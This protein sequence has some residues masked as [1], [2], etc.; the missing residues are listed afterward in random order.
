[1]ID[2]EA[3]VQFCEEYLAKHAYFGGAS[4]SGAD[5]MMYWPLDVSTRLNLVD[6]AQFPKI[7][8]WKK[9]IEARPALQRMR[10]KALPKGPVGAL[11]PLPQRAQGPRTASKFPRP[12]Q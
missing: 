5:I 4:L 7:A 10:A 2:S 12:P 3:A 9:V 8:A 6:A 1:M 11:R